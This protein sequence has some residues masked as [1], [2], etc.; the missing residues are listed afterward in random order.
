MTKANITEIKDFYSENK[1]VRSY[2]SRRFTG[3]GGAYINENEIQPNID[4]LLRFFN[5]PSK[6]RVLDIGAG[7]GRLSVP[8]K[9]AG[10]EVYCLD[11]SPE[12]VKVLEK[13]IPK[14]K[15]YIQSAFDRI[16]GSAKFD[17]ITGLRF[18]DHFEIGD[19]KKILENVKNSLKKDGVVVFSCLSNHGLESFI[20]PFFYF[21]KV[22]FYYSDDKYR[23]MFNK[24]GF[25]VIS[26]DSRFFLPRGLFLYSQRMPIVSKFFIFIDIVLRKLF[27]SSC[28]YLVYLLQSK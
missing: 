19:Q 2:N 3:L 13:E 23:K 9:K 21:G 24:C 11:S 4:F 14:N 20:S 25:K 1:V 26:K 7:R 5:N 12:M 6:T 16:K 17:S 28:S 18:F 27:P 22:N 15:I 8:V 10:F